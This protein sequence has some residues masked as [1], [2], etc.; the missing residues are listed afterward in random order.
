MLGVF[1]QGI[2]LNVLK[3]ADK[4]IGAKKTKSLDIEETRELVDEGPSAIDIIDT[5]ITNETARRILLESEKAKIHEL[6]G[7]VQRQ[8]G[9]QAKAIHDGI[10]RRFTT[11]NAEG[12]EVVDVVKLMETV[13]GKKMKNLPVLVLP[14]T[15]KLFIGERRNKKGTLLY[16]QI[17]DKIKKGP[18]SAQKCRRDSKDNFL[19]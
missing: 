6:I 15:I 16:E 9:E 4:I 3:R 1:L 12:K 17:A 5:K 11:I 10:R 18:R 7:D 2:I 13:K 8:K 14:E 19:V